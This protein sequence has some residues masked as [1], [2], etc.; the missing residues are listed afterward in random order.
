MSSPFWR[1]IRSACRV[2]GYSLR[3]EET[4]LYW[5]KQYIYFVK[6]RHPRECGAVEVAAFLT[7]LAEVRHVSINTQ[8]LA[9]NSLVFVYKNVLG[10]ELGE[11]GFSL[12]KK[13]TPL[14]TVLSSQDIFQILAVCEA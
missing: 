11:L 10:Q 3:T 14:P 13:Q 7:Y 8:K 1:S 9:L 2:R 6:K 5:T 4:Y 12:A